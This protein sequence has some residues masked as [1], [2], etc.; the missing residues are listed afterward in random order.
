MRVINIS[1]MYLGG[2][3]MNTQ[4]SKHPVSRT[5]THAPGTTH[6]SLVSGNEVRLLC[7]MFTVNLPMNSE[8]YTFIYYISRLFP[9]RQQ[10]IFDPSLLSCAWYELW[11]VIVHLTST[12]TILCI[13]H[14]PTVSLCF[15]IFHHHSS[16]YSILKNKACI[17]HFWPNL[18]IFIYYFHVVPL[19]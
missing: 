2:Q 3:T 5:H 15:L 9:N 8:V 14:K 6:D 11:V 18:Y 4:T 13:N 16:Y 19:Q 12:Q 17:S 7:R 10:S 1:R